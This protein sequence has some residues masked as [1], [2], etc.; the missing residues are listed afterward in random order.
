MAEPLEMLADAAFVMGSESQRSQTQLA[1][2]DNLGF[3]LSIAEENP[4]PRLHL[5]ARPDQRFPSLRI[6]LPR[7][8][9]FDFPGQML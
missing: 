6:K 3:Q 5:A 4:L 2:S 7:Q 9:N 8:E 1:A